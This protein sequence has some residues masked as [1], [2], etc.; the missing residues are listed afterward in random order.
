MWPRVVEIMLGCWMLASPFLFQHGEHTSWWINDFSVG[1]ALIV[2]GLLSFWRPT[3]RAHLVTLVVALWS[4][5]FGY[6]ISWQAE[7]PAPQ[8][9]ILIGLTLLLTAIIP[10]PASLPPREWHDQGYIQTPHPYLD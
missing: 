3:R 5:G 4:I 10:T 6:A 8:N 7:G 9:D 1:T 2:L